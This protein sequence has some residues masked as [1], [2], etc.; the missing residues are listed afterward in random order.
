MEQARLKLLPA[1]RLFSADGAR[2]AIQFSRGRGVHC[3]C[4]AARAGR[5][6]PH[7]QRNWYALTFLYLHMIENINL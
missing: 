5:G 4:R 1:P 7:A 6:H 2:L 3:Q